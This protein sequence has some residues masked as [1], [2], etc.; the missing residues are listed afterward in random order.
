MPKGGYILE[1]AAGNKCVSIKL[2]I[3]VDSFL[4][5]IILNCT[6]DENEI[7]ENNHIIFIIYL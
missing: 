7:W 6:S 3:F 1:Q 4:M 2:N 5:K